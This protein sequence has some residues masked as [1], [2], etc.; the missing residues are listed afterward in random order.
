[1]KSV[2]TRLT[3]LLLS[4]SPGFS[5]QQPDAA[6][7]EDVEQLLQVTGTRDNVQLMWAGMAQEAAGMAA[8]M[9]RRNHPNASP[10]EIRKAAEAIGTVYRRP[11]RCSR[12][13]N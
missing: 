5:Q 4:L 12:S 1:M 2:I 8:E 9:Y 10:L 6:T 11:S 3:F 13:T 7:K